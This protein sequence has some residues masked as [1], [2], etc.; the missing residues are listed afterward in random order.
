M[1][2]WYRHCSMMPFA[3]ALGCADMGDR[4]LSDLG[5]FGLIE[6]LTSG[7]ATSPA[8]ILGP[9]DDT[10]EVNLAGANVLITVDVLIENRHFR[11]DWSTPIDVGRKAAAASLA[12]IAAMGASASALVVA[13]AG[14]GDLPAAW[15]AACTAGLAQEADLVGAC[16]VGGDV[17]NADLITIAVTAIGPAPA[18]VVTRSGAQP[19]DV[20]AVAGRLGWS[21][22]GFAVLSRGFRS[23]RALVNAHRVPEPPYALGPQ[24]AHRGATAMIDISDGLIADARHLARASQVLVD[25]DSDALSVP[26]ELSAAAAAYNIDPRMWMLTGGE[27]HALLATF[28]ASAS[29]PAGFSIIG[30]VT[31]P[32]DDGPGVSVNHTFDH[33]RGG[34]QHFIA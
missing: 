9:G 19:G 14:P 1:A 16:I 3:A 25:L 33:S 15:A 6:K 7:L 10:A 24:A 11:K 2:S 8:V 21:A 28:P 17:S 31:A 34:Y 5:E 12:D 20:V 4:T 26:E 13:F 18:R 22:A 30:S 27:D 32:G 23:P 29:L